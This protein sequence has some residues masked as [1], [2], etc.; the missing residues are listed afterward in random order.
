ML[1]SRHFVY[2][3]PKKCHLAYR[4]RKQHFKED[5]GTILTGTSFLVL[6]IHS[7]IIDADALFILLPSVSI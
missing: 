2:H 5:L 7:T 3:H 4:I 6:D 1:H